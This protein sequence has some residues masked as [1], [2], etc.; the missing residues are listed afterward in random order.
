MATSM[1]AAERLATNR[2]PGKHQRKKKKERDR[3]KWLMFGTLPPQKK[4]T[5]WMGDNLEY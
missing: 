2:L 1:S 3:N 5:N 4:K